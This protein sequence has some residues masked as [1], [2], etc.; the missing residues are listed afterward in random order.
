MSGVGHSRIEDT[1]EVSF[2]AASTCSTLQQLPWVVS[3]NNFESNSE[4]PI[5]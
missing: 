3:V 2:Y 5:P 1:L 4:H